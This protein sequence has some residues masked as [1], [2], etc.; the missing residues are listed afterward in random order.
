MLLTARQHV[1]Y[2]LAHKAKLPQKEIADRLEVSEAAVSQILKRADARITALI[3][4]VGRDVAATLLAT[5]VGPRRTP[6]AA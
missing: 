4:R 2:V 3:G 1:V 6:T 5:E